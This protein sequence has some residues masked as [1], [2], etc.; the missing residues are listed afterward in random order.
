MLLR[1]ATVLAACF[2]AVLLCEAALWII[3]P[4]P[5]H[6]WAIWEPEGHIR[7]RL[8]PNQILRTAT[9]HEFRVNK[10][11]FQG[12]DYEWQKA[13]G[14]LRIEVF[15]GSAAQCYKAAGIEKSWPGALQIKLKNRLAMPVEVINLAQAG[16]ET[17]N[18]KIN[19]LCFGRAFNPDAI[20]VYHTFNDMAMFRALENT[21]Y[22]PAQ[23]HGTV[24]P[25]WQRIARATQIGCRARMA[26]FNVV[27]RAMDIISS[28][29]ERTGQDMDRPVPPHVFDW[30]RRNFADLAAWA[31]GDGVVPIL[32]TQ[33]GL[34][35][36]DNL[37]DPEIR[38]HFV[39]GCFERGFT[40]TRAVE[41]WLKINT[42]IEEVARQ[43][44]AI[45]VDGYNA[46]P[47]NLRHI[48]D[49]V[50]L[51]DEGSEVLAEEIANVLL[52]DQRFLALVDRVRA[53]TTGQGG[54]GATSR[55]SQ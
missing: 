39:G 35:A 55:S 1:G 14:T 34:G 10:Y 45:L 24:R 3:A 25:L 16:F 47:H 15:G 50:H 32:V 4:V 46:V 52:K 36:P 9:G 42:I 38:R 44:D 5:F 2:L 6:E 33:A 27:G 28:R 48:R 17:F 37:D 23:V 21:P 22:V 13:A 54:S 31:R 7:G 43:H 30:E 26:E 51:F 12:P 40:M 29:Q 41:V 20:I 19:Y 49:N 8:M 53:E 18:S 11:G